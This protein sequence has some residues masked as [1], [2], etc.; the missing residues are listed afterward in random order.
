MRALSLCIIRLIDV[1]MEKRRGAGRGWGAGHRG[2]WR[3]SAALGSCCVGTASMRFSDCR[4]KDRCMQVV[5]LCC[6]GAHIVS[7]PH[8]SAGCS[9]A[10][11]QRPPCLEPS[12]AGGRHQPHPLATAPAVVAARVPGAAGAASAAWRRSHRAAVWRSGAHRCRPTGLPAA[13]PET[14]QARRCG[15]W[16]Y[17][18]SNVATNRT[19]R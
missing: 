4:G 16:L 19:R 8:P 5:H 14:T 17:M 13:A 10:S 3:V 12:S 18:M 1:Q 7:L 11:R 6:H 2:T 9:A 15:F